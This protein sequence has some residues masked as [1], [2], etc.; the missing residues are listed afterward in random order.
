MCF[1]VLFVIDYGVMCVVGIGRGYW[2]FW[3]SRVCDY[4]VWLWLVVVDLY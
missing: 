2:W 3:C 4:C 1:I